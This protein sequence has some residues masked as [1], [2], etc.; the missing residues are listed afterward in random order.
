[1]VSDWPGSTGSMAT[2]ITFFNFAPFFLSSG[3]INAKGAAG[4]ESAKPLMKI[5]MAMLGG[6]L[7]NI[8]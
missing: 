3:K 5:A 1:M 2:V 8:A 7:I 6:E 4:A